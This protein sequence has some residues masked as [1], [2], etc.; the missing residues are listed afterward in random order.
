MHTGQL[1]RISCA[2]ASM[3]YVHTRS[4]PEQ[5]PCTGRQ[6]TVEMQLGQ[7]GPQ[8]WSTGQIGWAGSNGS[9]ITFQS[10]A[11]FLEWSRHVLYRGGNLFE[12]S[13]G[14][15][16]TALRTTVGVWAMPVPM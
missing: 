7:V 3:D 14:N 1:K 15:P 2:H 8:E 10:V 13:Y 9:T 11:T 16:D 4:S 12:S 5:L 6:L